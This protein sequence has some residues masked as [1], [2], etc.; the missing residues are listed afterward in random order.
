MLL[1][2][3]CLCPRVVAAVG[4]NQLCGM[5]VMRQNDGLAVVDTK[6]PSPLDSVS[7]RRNR[8]LWTRFLCIETESIGLDFYAEKTESFRL[9]F[10]LRFWLESH[11]A[12][13]EIE[14]YLL[15]LLKTKIV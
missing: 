14:P 10:C 2:S 3:D 9:V 1:W 8:V 6:K 12:T 11:S 15:E 5:G 7:L 13:V 4:S